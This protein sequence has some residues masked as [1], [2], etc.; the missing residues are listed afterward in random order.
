MKQTE[1]LNGDIFIIPNRSFIGEFVFVTTNAKVQME[2]VYYKN[3]EFNTNN[4]SFDDTRWIECWWCDPKEDNSNWRDHGIERLEDGNWRLST[5]YVPTW[6]FNG[7]REGDIVTFKM[8]VHKLDRENELSIYS[9]VK[10]SVRLAQSKYR[11]RQ[12]GTFEEVLKRV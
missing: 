12:F 1:I 10:I 9:T 2:T 5:S 8:P 11:Y 6:L 4:V 3:Q 7:H